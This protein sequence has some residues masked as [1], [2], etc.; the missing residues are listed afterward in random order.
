MSMIKNAK[1]ELTETFTSE[2]FITRFIDIM[3]G[4]AILLVILVHAAAY[5]SST[6][7]SDATNFNF[8]SLNIFTYGLAGVSVFFFIS[9]FLLDKL[10]N[11]PTFN[12]K[13]YAA[14]R[15]GRIFPAWLFWSTL[16]IIIAIIGLKNI[17]SEPSIHTMLNLY[18]S[19]PVNSTDGWISIIVSLLFL[20]FLLPMSWNLLVPGGW[21]IQTEMWNYT[22]FPIINKIKLSYSIM[23]IIT[24]QLIEIYLEKTG[25]FY[26]LGV[27]PDLAFK[28]LSSIVTGP[29][30]FIS[31]IIFS[32]FLRHLKTQE[33]K[34]KISLTEW[35]LLALLYII[36]A[37]VKGPTMPQYYGFI[38]I[39][40]A[41]LAS[42]MIEKMAKTSKD[43]I[44]IGKYSYGIYFAHFLFIG[45]TSWA[46]LSLS[47]AIFPHSNNILLL[48]TVTLLSS[49][50]TLFLSYWVARFTFK[51]IENPPLEW[52]KKKF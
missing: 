14:R 29:V 1:K 19:A 6:I 15:I 37:S 40:F 12:I 3:R 30:W 10:Y 27:D 28:S 41:I 48:L 39:T 45:F 16:S 5:V 26:T 51:F 32:R 35:L 4:I 8:S 18:G 38:V 13:R 47:E 49:A 22:L 25:W 42:I 11:K 17:F 36:T 43:I 23:F 7:I 33:T 24:L 31:G 9:G 50:V 34:D 44:N 20:G 52:V 46:A 2:T 21:S